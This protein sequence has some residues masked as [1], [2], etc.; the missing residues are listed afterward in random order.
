MEDAG[1]RLRQF[2]ESHPNLMVITGAGLS[3]ASRI[4]DYRDDE[5][6]WKRKPPV[7]FRDFMTEE[8]VRKRYWGRSLVGWRYFSKAEPNAAH[9]ALVALES[10]GIVNL[11]VTQNVDDLH[12]RAGQRRLLPLHGTLNR[13]LCMV[14]GVA[15]PR[16]PFQS[17]LVEMN[18]LFSD[19]GAEAAP[20][21]DAELDHI[22]F[23]GFR[24]PDCLACGGI[25]K[26]D[27]VFYGESVPPERHRHAETQLQSSAGLL[28][29]GSSLMVYSG[30]RL[31]KKANQMG[32]PVAALNRGK[33]R[34]DPLLSLKV[35][36]PAERALP[37]LVEALSG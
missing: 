18:P 20:D 11:V 22:A 35:E 15:E 1:H 31:A 12:Q 28:I 10:V 7:M 6:N 16:V 32:L 5:G 3:T 13:V 37:G 17:R 36:Q 14:C 23:D 9:H 2:V 25:L 8:A 34:A 4:P 21:G 27:A 19:L 33:T 24:V 30:F 29:V 26:P